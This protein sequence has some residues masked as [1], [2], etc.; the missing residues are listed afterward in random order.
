PRARSHR[1]TR[2]R[3]R[4]P[5]GPPRPRRP[6]AAEGQVAATAERLRAAFCGLG[7][8]CAGPLPAARLAVLC[9]PPELK[10]LLAAAQEFGTRAACRLTHQHSARGAAL[11]GG[12]GRCCWWCGCRP[13]RL[14]AYRGATA[15]SSGSTSSVRP[16]ARRAR[17]RPR[18]LTRSA[19]SATTRWC[20]SGG[21]STRART[22]RRTAGSASPRA[23]SSTSSALRGG[24]GGA[25]RHAT[26]GEQLLRGRALHA[27][28][29]LELRGPRCAARGGP[30]G[31]G[32]GWRGRLRRRAPRVSE[33]ACERGGLVGRGG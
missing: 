33:P 28:S 4:S 10:E 16:R 2:T 24:G 30:G 22:A 20:A 23:A 18:G 11:P 1:E 5:L 21:S 27:R 31:G 25:R 3:G 29:V 15:G 14:R 6:M 13:L 19:S 12:G 26:H 7:R 17:R 8:R 32:G 9:A